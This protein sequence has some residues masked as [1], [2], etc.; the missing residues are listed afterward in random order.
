VDFYLGNP[1]DPL[2]ASDESFILWNKGPDEAGQY[3]FEKGQVLIKGDIAF[4]AAA[5]DYDN[6]GD[7]D[8]FIGIG[9]QEG[10]GLDHLFRNSGGVFTDVSGGAGIRGPKDAQGR[11]VPKATSS[12]TWADYDNDGDLDL[13]VAVR[14]VVQIAAGCPGRAQQPIPQR[15]ARRLVHGRHGRGGRGQHREQHD[16]SLGRLRQRRVGGPLRPHRMAG[17]PDHPAGFEL[18]RNMHDGTFRRVPIRPEQVNFGTAANWASSAADFNNDGWIDI[19]S[20]AE[21]PGMFSWRIPMPC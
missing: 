9:G 4:T 16:R 6:D 19:W 15:R 3:H 8:L 5:A 12:G 18:Y 17:W 10:I 14:Y 13:F 11:F 21:T 2:V 20:E 7:E 1:G